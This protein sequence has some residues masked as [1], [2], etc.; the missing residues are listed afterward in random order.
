MRLLSRTP[1][2][3]LALGCA[4]P[5]GAPPAATTPPPVVEPSPPR[6]A[7]PP[8]SPPPAPAGARIEDAVDR[9]HGVEVH[10]PYRWMERG[11]AELDAFLDQQASRARKALAA[12]PGRDALRDDLRK[13]NRG[14]TRVWLTGL[15]GPIGRPRV[16]LMKREPDEEQA[17]LWMRVGWDGEDRLLVDPRRRDHDGIHHTLDYATPAPSGKHVAYGISASGSEDSTIEIVETDG[18]TLRPEKIDRAQYAGIDWRDDSSFFYWRRRRPAPGESKADWFKNSATYLHVLGDDPE[19]AQPVMGPMIKPL[20]IGAEE[21]TWVDASPKSPWVVGGASPGT[22]ADPSYFVAPRSAVVPGAAIPWRR[23]C[24]PKDHVVGMIAR[25]HTLYALSYDHATRYRVLTID[26][27]KGTIATARVFV[28]EGPL[29]IEGFVPAPEGLYLQLLDAG[30]SRISRVS[31]DGKTREEVPLP[32]PGSAY[33]SADIDRPGA[34]FSLEGWTRPPAD[35]EYVPK[36]GIRDLALKPKWPRD[37][38]HVSSQ[39]AEVKSKDGTAVAVSIVYPKG[40]AL[41]GS[42]PAIVDG[43]QAYASVERPYFWAV[44]LAWVERGGVYAL[45]HGRGSGAR[46]KQW[47]LDGTKHHKENG[48]DDFIACAEHLVASKYTTPARLTVTGTSAG[49]VLAG[50]ALTKR[51]ELYAA[52]LL[53]VPMSNLLRF[54]QTEGGPANVPEWGTV[55]DAGDFKHL[56]ASDPFHRVKDGTRYPAVL[57]TGGRHD[58]RVPIWQPAKLAARLQAAST[59]GRPILL[60]VEAEAGHG[61]GSTRSQVEEEWADLYAFAL[62]Q[63]G[64]ALSRPTR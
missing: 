34:R 41:D 39:E 58:V 45:C 62:E 55:T 11:G 48:V 30:A 10:D 9:L 32:Y 63:S 18:G 47:H 5:K 61:L 1:V 2:L 19:R 50:G 37:Y 49:G 7:P 20:G 27:R 13:A 51:P 46:G 17:Q 64:I 56:L 25:G 16:F 14:V 38:A 6:P 23:V 15:A 4:A 8:Q 53:R 43:Y 57:L 22:S 60:R 54:E 28:P 36:R 26:A 12:I 42:A 33:V 59:S 29:V 31:W 40:L 35:F 21:F 52:A 44:R 24:G 3:L